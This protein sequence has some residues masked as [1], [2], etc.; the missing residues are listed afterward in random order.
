MYANRCVCIRTISDCMIEKCYNFWAPP[1]SLESKFF[2][3]YAWSSQN[4]VYQIICL[5]YRMTPKLR[6]FCKKLSDFD[7][8]PI[9]FFVLMRPMCSFCWINNIIKSWKILWI[10]DFGVKNDPKHIMGDISWTVAPMAK[11]FWIMKSLVVGEDYEK[12]REIGSTDKENI[13][14]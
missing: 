9:I 14:H 11:S 1:G 7:E 12:Y 8:W 2:Q 6:L 10:N 13:T 3:E 5:T 4:V